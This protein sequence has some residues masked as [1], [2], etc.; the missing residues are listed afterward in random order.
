RPDVACDRGPP[1][2]QRANGP[3]A[4]RQC[5]P[6]ARRHH[7]HAGGDDRVARSTD[8]TPKYKLQGQA[9]LPTNR[10]DK[11]YPTAPF[12]HKRRGGMR[13]GWGRHARLPSL[14]HECI[15]VALLPAI[16][17]RSMSLQAYFAF[18]AACLAL[19]LLPGPI[20]TLLIA[21]GLRHG[22]RAALT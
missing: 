21:N 19:A 2:H 11:G 12:V 18:I 13:A 1:P 17:G 7:S 16:R 4:Y 3:G 14:R 8:P 10:K 20:V 9:N 22:T 5:S 6:Q 15:M